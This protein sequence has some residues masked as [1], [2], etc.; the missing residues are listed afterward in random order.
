ME[1]EN[2]ETKLFGIDPISYKEWQDQSQSVPLTAEKV[3][4]A[5]KD[6]LDAIER[7]RREG[8]SVGFTDPVG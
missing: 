5:A 6:Y 4:S 2:K 3:L 7:M 1:E 8:V